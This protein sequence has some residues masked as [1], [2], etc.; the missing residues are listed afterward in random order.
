MDEFAVH[1]LVRP[2]RHPTR[3]GA[4]H[5]AGRGD[6]SGSHS[7]NELFVWRGGWA[8][9]HVQPP[10]SDGLPGAPRFCAPA[11]GP[12]YIRRMTTVRPRIAFQGTLGAFSEDAIRVFW[13]PDTIPVPCETF[14]SMLAAVKTGAADGAVLPVE[15][16]TVGPITSALDALDDF[17]VGLNIGGTTDIP[18]VHALMSVQGAALEGVKV[19]TSHPVALAQ[20]R[21]FLQAFG[22]KVEAFYD[23]AGAAKMVR[24]KG[25]A[26][27]AAVASHTAALRYGLT[28]L[29]D[30]IQDEPDN[31]T[32]FVRIERGN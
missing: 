2:A 31:W 32:R 15:N 23:T 16:L 6:P 24:E 13:G 29:A 28:V 26:R 5:E 7:G 17:S 11:P 25:D 9:K 18:I 1:D 8:L 4:V 27:I 20:C 21:R 14:S 3:T 30:G 19:I 12:G 10:V 22:A